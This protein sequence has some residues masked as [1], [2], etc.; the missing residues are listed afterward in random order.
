MRDTQ[1]YAYKM[2]NFEQGKTLAFWYIARKMRTRGELIQKLRYK[3]YPLDI[4][5]QVADYMREL[6]YIDDADYA[7]RYIKDA[8]GIKKCGRSRIVR[9]LREKRV[10]QDVIDEAFGMLELD[11]G[12]S[13]RDLVA[14]RAKHYDLFNPKEKKRFVDYLA[15][16]WFGLGDI[17]VS[18][19]ELNEQ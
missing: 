17:L 19:S 2:Y 3:G 10:S 16:R 5:N 7:A 9:E 8:H 14:Q 11:F 15:R 4:A 6:A 18:L 13:L 1:R 12:D